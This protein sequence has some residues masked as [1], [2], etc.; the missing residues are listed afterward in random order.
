[1][2]RR[3]VE[4]RSPRV[5]IVFDGAFRVTGTT[6]NTGTPNTPVGP[7]RVRLHDQAS[8][9]LLRE[10]WSDATTGAYSFN[11]IRAG[12]Y[13]VA[14]FDHTGL[15]GGVIETDVVAEPMP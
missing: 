5:N 6:S 4:S 11:R 15:Y 13:Y 14:A 2:T 9:S 10:V 3:A 8:G 12:V 1:M 7:R